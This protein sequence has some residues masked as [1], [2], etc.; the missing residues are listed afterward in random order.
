MAQMFGLTKTAISKVHVWGIFLG[1]WL[2]QSKAPHIIFILVDDLGWNDVSMHGSPEIPTPNIDSLSATG[3]HLNNYYVNPVCSPTR[4]SLMS[5]RSI[6]HHGIYTPFGSGSDSEGLNLSYTLLPEHLKQSYGYSTYMVGKWHL[7]MKTA[8]YLPS[9]R[10]F[11]RHFGYYSGIMD[12]WTHGITSEGPPVNGGLDLHQGGRD[13]R[14]GLWPRGTLDDPIYNT[15]GQYSTSMFAHKA[16]EWIQDHA[17]KKAAT[18][19]F[20]Y[21]AFQG[22]HSADNQFVQ[23]PPGLIKSFESLSPGKTCGQWEHPRKGNCSK[24]AMRKT[25]AAAVTAVDEAVGAIVKALKHAGIYKDTLIVLSTDNGGP[26]DG[27]DNNNMN[28][29]PLR[30]CKGGYFEGG[31]RGVGLIHGA[32]VKRT[33]YSSQALHH[34]VDWLPTLLA[35]AKEGAFGQNNGHEI[36]LKEGEMPFLPGDGINNWLALST[37]SPSLR[38]EIIHVVQAE[39][40]DLESHASRQGT[41]KLI[42]HPA[43][44]DCSMTHPGW[45]P[46]PNQGSQYANFTIQCPPPPLKIDQCSKSE[47]CLFNIS[48]DPCEHVNLAD[49]FPQ[50]VTSMVAKMLDYRRHAVLSWSKF[51]NY[52][53]RSDPARHGPHMFGYQ[54]LYGPWLDLDEDAKYYP[55]N[56]SGPGYHKVVIKCKSERKPQ[57]SIGSRRALRN[58]HR[59]TVN[60]C[61]S[62]CTQ[63]LN[64]LLA[65]W[66]S[67]GPAHHLGTCILHDDVKPAHAE[68]R[69]VSANT[70]FV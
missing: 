67:N 32:G 23:A 47:P 69:G 41:M 18:P 34:V 58:V 64:C 70:W 28:N 38:D 2:C 53:P 35:A 9:H 45:Y 68:L 54:G 60:D 11:D 20:M 36:L 43:S 42:W 8:D 10:G 57:I 61:C 21:V 15:S 13:F 25:V 50:L 1:S 48:N 14:D 65:I 29:F 19:M 22:C 6:I 33:G 66:M 59:V 37:G 26:T 24:A 55:T 56:Y 40:S 51:R 5:G 30:G 46:P 62:T 31:M 7:G 27:T 39:G 17:Y 3:V 52:D 4:A 12:Y 63:T 16:V 44:S 49:R